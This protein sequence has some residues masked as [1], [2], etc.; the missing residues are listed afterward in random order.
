[1]ELE[2][3]SVGIRDL[4]AEIE[5]PVIHAVFDHIVIGIE[6]L[7][8]V[9]QALERPFPVDAAPLGKAVRQKDFH[10]FKD[11]F[12]LCFFHD[13]LLSS[14][15]GNSGFLILILR[16]IQ[17]PYIRKLETSIVIAID[18]ETQFFAG[19]LDLLDDG[20]RD[21]PVGSS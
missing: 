1:M 15:R 18:V 17:A 19:N 13:V 8:G 5:N 14:T 2:L 9:F 12:T 7:L 3:H 10:L 20:N 21:I 4:D 6:A 16:L 11:I